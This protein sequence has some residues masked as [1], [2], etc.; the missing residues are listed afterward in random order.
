[1]TCPVRLLRGSAVPE[2]GGGGGGGIR[3]VPDWVVTCRAVRAVSSALVWP[4]FVC[5]L[6]V[7]RLR[8]E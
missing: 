6:L 4:A 1:M 5:L 7:V 3:A 8:Q 2:G